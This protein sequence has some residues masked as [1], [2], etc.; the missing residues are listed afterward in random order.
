MT[1]SGTLV[2]SL[3][4]PLPKYCWTS[5]FSDQRAGVPPTAHARLSAF[6]K[7][8][9]P[10]SVSRLQQEP[11]VQASGSQFINS[12]PRSPL[13][14]LTMNLMSISLILAIRSKSGWSTHCQKTRSAAASYFQEHGFARAPPR[15]TASIAHAQGPGGKGQASPLHA[16]ECEAGKRHTNRCV[17]TQ[18]PVGL[19]S[20]ALP[21]MTEW[22]VPQREDCHRVG[23]PSVLPCGVGKQGGCES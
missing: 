18:A 21:G 13:P 3:H 8:S 9:G 2:G 4:H 23:S 16:W 12:T 5:L 14:S 11:A 22:C 1:L 20:P 7:A 6:R 19:A 15:R 17:Q 10:L